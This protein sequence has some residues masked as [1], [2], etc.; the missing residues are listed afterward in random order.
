VILSPHHVLCLIWCL[1]GLPSLLPINS[2]GTCAVI[3]L[4]GQTKYAL[5]EQIVVSRRVTIM[6]TPFNNPIVFGSTAPR[7]F[8]VVAGGTLDVRFVTFYNGRPEFLTDYLVIAQGGAIRILLGGVGTSTCITGQTNCKGMMMFISLLICLQHPGCL[9][10]PQL[11]SRVACSVSLP[12]FDFLSLSL[13][14]PKP[15][16]W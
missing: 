6:G 8:L 2:G 11:S 9:I 14:T 16:V 7:A 10:F 1:F 3:T 15:P 13:N 5:P 4:T 12:R